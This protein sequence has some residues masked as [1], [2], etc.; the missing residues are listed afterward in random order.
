MN[1]KKIGV[2]GAT[3]YTGSEIVRILS[4]HPGVEI[5]L[6]TSEARAGE[7]FSDV[8]PFF[9]G[10]VDD[11]LHPADKIDDTELDLVFLALPH[12]VSMEYVKRF[13]GR[14]FRIVDFSGDFRLGSAEVYEQWYPGEHA[15]PE[16]FE[17]AVYGLP[18]LFADAVHEAPLVANP[19]CFPTGA[20]LAL[21]PLVDKRL[22]ADEGIII[23]S[24]TGVTGAGI[25]ASAT[26]MFSN[27]N[28]NFKAY[29]L[30]THRHTIEIQRILEE[31]AVRP[32]GSR[33]DAGAAPHADRKANE[34]AAASSTDAFRKNQLA[35][36]QFTPHLLPV[37]RGI[38][39]TVYARPE[40]AGWITAGSGM[41]GSGKEFLDKVYLD[42]YRDKPFVRICDQ[43]PA[44]K[45]VR[46]S[47]Y[48]NIYVDFDER[49]GNIIVISAIDNLVKGAAGLAVQNMNVMFGFDET[50]G[51]RHIPVS[52]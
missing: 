30:K 37:D 23:D 43:P 48:C 42:Y 13:A 28:D 22:V 9:R 33:V 26:N 46:A 31:L 18:E 15:W 7:K 6:I 4:Q 47:N 36:V 12:G 8:H 1:K 3:G 27:V 24:K 35:P 32:S 16:G 39:T 10:I 45:E 5:T 41:H 49:T 44:L 50:E 14:D 29:G 19:G 34:A 25:K 11:Q 52:P 40:A 20:I 21:A 17:H 2:I 51:L 38:L